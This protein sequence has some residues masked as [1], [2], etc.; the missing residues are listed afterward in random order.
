MKKKI[1]L[2]SFVGFSCLLT[3]CIKDTYRHQVSVVYPANLSVL[4]ADQTSD[5]VKFLTFDSFQAKSYETDWIE[6]LNTKNNP[7]SAEIQ[8]SYYNC[9]EVCVKLA[10]DPNTSSKARNGYVSI[11]SFSKLDDWDQTAHAYFKQL[12]WHNV[13]RPEPKYGLD[14][15]QSVKT[16]TFVSKDS[17]LQVV[18]TL[19]FVAYTDWTLEQPDESFIK[20]AVTEGKAGNNTLLLT[21]EPNTS[22]EERSADLKLKSKNGV[23]TVITYNQAG[24]KT[25]E[26]K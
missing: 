14:D 13:M 15:N 25:D 6:V 4:Y 22:S 1:A 10:V 3:S 19:R 8:N 2:F 26:K 9:Y 23:T 20:S 17:A 12:G 21:L 24:K 16:C 11:R 5:S 18:D 7:S